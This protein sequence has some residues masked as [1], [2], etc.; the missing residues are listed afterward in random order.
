VSLAL[1]V[2]VP[3]VLAYPWQ[4]VR[5]RSV[6]AV[7]VVVAVLLLG[8]WRGLHF[9][10]LLR[11]RLGMR[12][13]ASRRRHASHFELQTTELL[14]VT[15]PNAEAD[16]L[17]FAL[18]TKYLDR[19]GIRADTVRVTSRDTVTRN[20]TRHRQTWLGLT[21]SAATN[22]SALQAR[23]ARI[24][25]QETAQVAARRLAD[26]LREKGWSAVATEADDVPRVFGPS[27]RDT[28][29]GVSES[30]AGYIAAYR[31][32][33][34]A[35]LPDTL[36]AIQSNPSPETWTALE[37]ARAGNDY[38]VAVACALRS[39]SEP[40]RAAPLPGLRPQRGQHR[41]ALLALD[42]LSAQRLDGHTEI[43]AGLL[44]R[45]RWPATEKAYKPNSVAALP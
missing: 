44:E 32:N 6:L 30:N 28:W 18:I 29:R 21:V 23:S 4:T 39:E 22:L 13:T 33:V 1:L 34:D 19:Y 17:P 15:P 38:T 8:W 31:V 14:E 41:A 37:I 10:T 26:E 43:P 3:A 42:S 36:A 27:A 2:A 11:R 5:E 7:A 9:T 16:A 20:G 24:P 12:R 45:L 25:L 35:D 40:A